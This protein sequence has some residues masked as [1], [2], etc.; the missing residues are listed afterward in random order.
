MNSLY[1]K[2]CV[3]MAVLIMFSLGTKLIVA[4]KYEAVLNKIALN[5]YKLS[6]I[7]NAS[8]S[9][10]SV[11]KATLTDTL[12]KLSNTVLSDDDELT[13]IITNFLKRDVFTPN[14]VQY[15]NSVNI[16]QTKDELVSTI[17]FISPLDNGLAITQ[18]LEKRLWVKDWGLAPV[19]ISDQAT[20]AP[21]GGQDLFTFNISLR[22]SLRNK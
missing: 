10:N 13:L 2:L 17:T 19:T 14:H 8:A 16:S 21:V 20:G 9:V 7:D 22:I 4:P 11:D 5:E 15:P 18:E 6:L 12:K 3:G 1:A